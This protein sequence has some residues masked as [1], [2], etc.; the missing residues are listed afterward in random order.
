MG[1]QFVVGG[2]PELN[3]ALPTLS[4]DE[5]AP[6]PVADVERLDAASDQAGHGGFGGAFGRVGDD[7]AVISHSGDIA[8]SYWYV[9]AYSYVNPVMAEP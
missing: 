6:S 3:Q 7:G 8:E 4:R 1:G 5:I 9:K 2:Q